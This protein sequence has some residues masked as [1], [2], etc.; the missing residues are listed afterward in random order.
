MSQVIRISEATYKRLEL[1]AVGFDTPGNVID[2]LLDFYSKHEATKSDEMLQS[3]K[4]K[5]SDEILTLD[6]DNPEDLTHTKIIRAQFGDSYVKTWMR[7]VVTAHKYALEH[8]GTFSKLQEMSL[9]NITEGPFTENGY[10]Y[11][12]EVGISIQGENANNSWRN[13]LH[14]A[15]EINIPLIEIVFQWRSNKKSVRPRQK[16]RLVW[17]SK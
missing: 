11:F 7:L 14:I 15:R 2:R 16:A 9:S 1:L 3:P 5:Y 4:A 10:R 17:P 8:V 12:P 6:P 13:A